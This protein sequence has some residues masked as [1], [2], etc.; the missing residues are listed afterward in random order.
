MDTRPRSE[1]DHQ[2]VA[3]ASS[4]TTRYWRAKRA[5]NQATVGARRAL[6]DQ[7]GKRASS[8][9]APSTGR[10]PVRKHEEVVVEADGVVT[11]AGRPAD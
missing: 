8:R 4:T 2:T 5:A 10:E 3:V 7:E 1:R 6:R 9:Q 11:P